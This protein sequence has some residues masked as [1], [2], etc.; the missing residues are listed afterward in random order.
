M[1][2]VKCQDVRLI[3]HLSHPRKTSV[4]AYTPEEKFSVKYKDF[5]EV[6]RMCIA[7]GPGAFMGKSDVKSAFRNL[8]IRPQDWRWLVMKARNPEDG[9][10]YFFT[11]KCV[12]FGSRISCSHFQIFSDTMEW[13]FKHRTGK[14]SNNYL[15][16][17]FFVTLLKAH[18]D[19]LLQ[20]FLDLCQEVSFPVSLEKTCW[21]VQLIVF[22]GL[23]INTGTQTVSIPI[24]KSNETTQQNVQQEENYSTEDSAAHG[25][26]KFYL[27]R[28]FCRK[29]IYKEISF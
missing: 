29:A 20:A 6:V 9:L 24:D 2:D 22:L 14:R 8:P 28:D 16:D 10:I 23:L 5:D 26:I 12:P 7:A 15:D 21:G 4:N 1:Q 11:D 19:S 25:P 27:Q 3:F 13:I 18:C 17:F